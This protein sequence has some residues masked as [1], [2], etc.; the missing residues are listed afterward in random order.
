V[1]DWFYPLLSSVYDCGEQFV[2]FPNQEGG[3]FALMSCIALALLRSSI[4]YMVPDTH[5]HTIESECT[6]P[7]RGRLVT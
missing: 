2:H 6:I 4:K 1:N 7:Y 5:A 3:V